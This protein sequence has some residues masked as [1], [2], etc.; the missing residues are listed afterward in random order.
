ME[1][2]RRLAGGLS[3]SQ[4]M[5]SFVEARAAESDLCF[6]SHTIGVALHLWEVPGAYLQYAEELAPPPGSHV[7]EGICVGRRGSG[8]LSSRGYFL[9][10]L[11][12]EDIIWDASRCGMTPA[13]AREAY[14]RSEST[15]EPLLTEQCRGL[16]ST[17]A[18]GLSRGGWRCHP[19]ELESLTEA[20]RLLE[21]KASGEAE[22]TAAWDLALYVHLAGLPWRGPQLAARVLREVRHRGPRRRRG[23]R[24]G[25]AGD[26][27][28]SALAAKVDADQ[29][30][31]GLAFP[32][33]EQLPLRRVHWLYRE[34]APL[35][36]GGGG[37]A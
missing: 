8:L 32:R 23:K 1:S 33:R 4:R 15:L 30:L 21:A 28:L 6:I 13:A 5:I 17:L 10:A 36:C 7:F 22:A 14:A 34:E 2:L 16:M 18:R 25:R 37:A 19:L 35:L 12:P 29:G 26:A 11:F 27:V 31:L 20:R 9:V 24:R 3:A